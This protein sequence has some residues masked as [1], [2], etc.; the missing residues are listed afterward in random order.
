M[1]GR[2][3]RARLAVGLG[4]AFAAALGAPAATASDPA[5]APAPAALRVYVVRHAQAWKNVPASERPAGM[6]GA[7]L[8]ALT[9]DGDAQAERIGKSL[10]GAGLA[11]VVASPARRARQTAEGIA[12]GAGAPEPETQDA[13]RPLDNGT[14]PRAADSRWR[15][16]NW[17][18]GADPRP[19][20][21]ESLADGLERAVRAIEALAARHP[22]RSVVVVTHGEITAALRSRALG[23]SPLAGHA[24][25]FVAE[26]T[27]SAIDVGADG[28]WTLATR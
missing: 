2:S 28:R 5:A 8:D 22:G 16:R 25:Q 13:F 4:L 18:A 11:A 26:G 1:F 9:P 17:S 7:A 24:K 23:I 6:A 12:R 3:A 15:T 27:V 21:G 10:A 20:G 19:P 14:D